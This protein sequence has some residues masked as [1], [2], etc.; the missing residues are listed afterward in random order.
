MPPGV[1]SLNE[2]WPSHVSVPAMKLLS[3]YR[4]VS[5]MEERPAVPRR[6]DSMRRLAPLVPTLAA[7]AADGA[8]SHRLAFYL[9]LLAIPA[10]VAAGL[11]R[12][13]AALDGAGASVEAV[14]SGLALALIVLSE[15][16]R[17]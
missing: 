13:A 5:V 9:L 4:A 12:L 7:A 14:L 16:V 2:A 17:G 6:S 1:S 11:D 3:A 15:A 10:A 8:G